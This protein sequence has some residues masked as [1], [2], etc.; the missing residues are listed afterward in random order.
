[1]LFTNHPS[2]KLARTKHAKQTK[3]KNTYLFY[4]KKLPTE[5]INSAVF[6]I[7]HWWWLTPVCIRILA[8]ASHKECRPIRKRHFPCISVPGKWQRSRWDR[9]MGK[10]RPVDLNGK[11]HN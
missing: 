6:V 2:G 11:K 5:T 7:S 10:R 1:M 4:P 8:F 3:L 9:A